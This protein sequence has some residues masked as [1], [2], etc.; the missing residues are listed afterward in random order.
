V[1]LGWPQ[2]AQVIGD[3]LGTPARR[4]AARDAPAV[5][6]EAAAC[7]AAVI[8]FGN[9]RFTAGASGNA[10]SFDPE[11]DGTA[12][13]AAGD[14]DPYAGRLRDCCAAGDLACQSGLDSTVDGHVSYFSNGMRADGV[15]FILHRVAAAR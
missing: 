1:L 12:P 14:L 15:E 7:I 2:G 11:L 4:L 3:T 9:P 10:G 8:L 5:S 13:R 6:P